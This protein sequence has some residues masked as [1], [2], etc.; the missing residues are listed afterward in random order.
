MAT[1]TTMTATP[2]DM[3]RDLGS[4]LSGLEKRCLVWL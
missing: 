2:D 1:T 4:I 3:T